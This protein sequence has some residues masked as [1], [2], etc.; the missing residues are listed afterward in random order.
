MC[1]CLCRVREDLSVSDGACVCVCLSRVRE[2]LSALESEPEPSGGGAVD[3]YA[4]RKQQRDNDELL[5]TNQ[6]V[7]RSVGPR[8]LA[9]PTFE[10]CWMSLKGLVSKTVRADRHRRKLSEPV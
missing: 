4:T 9:G 6:P 3:E 10:I 2:D 7:R 5:H 8:I 1:A